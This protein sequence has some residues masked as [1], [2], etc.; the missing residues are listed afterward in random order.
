VNDGAERTWMM[1]LKSCARSLGRVE[2][3]QEQLQIGNGLTPW[4]PLPY[5]T[6]SRLESSRRPHLL[7]SEHPL[8]LAE[9]SI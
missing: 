4:K 1:L 2:R 3:F 8:N 9:A 5:Y 6:R 7:L